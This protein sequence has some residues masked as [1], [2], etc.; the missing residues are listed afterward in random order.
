METRLLTARD[1]ISDR[2]RGLD[3]GANDYL[4]KPFAFLLILS[5]AIWFTT[6]LLCRVKCQRALLPLSKMALSAAAFDAENLANQRLPSIDSNDE[7]ATLKNV[8]DG[9][10]T[11]N[12]LE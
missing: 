2:V 9:T 6:L 10:S 4:C 3:Q 12:P 7:L 11:Y 1:A 5:L 8:V